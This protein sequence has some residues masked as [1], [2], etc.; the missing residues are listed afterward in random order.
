M[1]E[2]PEHSHQ[3]W[4]N[5]D[6]SPFV[7]IL[8]VSKHFGSVTAVN[9]VSLDIYKGELFCLLGSSGCGKSTLLRMLAGLET[10]TTGRIEIDGQ[11][12]TGKAPWERPTNIMF[13][14]YALFPHMS[15]ERN[16]AYGLHRDGVP[17]RVV[18][19]AGG[20]PMDATLYLCQRAVELTRPAIADA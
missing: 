3:P 6:E 13:Q 10:V 11:D 14:S 20:A 8:K 19:S 16:I 1:N 7:R 17:P 15:V 5:I 4:R 2:A 12:M 18:I 9:D